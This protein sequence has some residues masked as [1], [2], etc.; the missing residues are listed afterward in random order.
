M[1]RRRCAACERLTYDP[2]S[3]VCTRKG[4]RLSIEPMAILWRLRA[5]LGELEGLT[6]RYV[7]TDDHTVDVETL[8]VLL[9]LRGTIRATRRALDDLTDLATKG[10]EMRPISTTADDVYDSIERTVT[11]RGYPPSITELANEHRCSRSTIK[12]K[13]DELVEVGRIR[14]QPGIPR[15]LTLTDREGSS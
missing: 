3:G 8:F 12:K 4:C 5:A 11:D 7:A 6:D 15:A 13:L 2:R 1:I 9:R 10:D 14:R